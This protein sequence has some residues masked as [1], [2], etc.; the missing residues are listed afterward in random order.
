MNNSGSGDASGTT[1]NGSAPRTISYNTIGA[2]S[3]TGANASGTWSITAT[4]NVLSRGW[5]NWNDSTVINNVVGI[6]AWKNYGNNHVIFD[7]SQGTSPS[8]ASVNQTNS[9]VAWTSSY[10]TL[11]GWNGSTTYGVRVDSARLAD[12]ASTVG[13]FSAD[14]FYRNLGFGSGFPSWNLNTVDENRSGFT[15]SNNAP[16]TGPFIH[17]GASGY[18]LQFN[19][20]YGGDGY[21]LAFRSKNGDTGNWNSWRYPAVYGVNANGGG[22]LYS[23]IYYDQNDTAYYVDPNSTSNIYR[24]TMNE[25]I[26]LGVFPNSTTNTGQAWIGRAADRLSGTMTVQLGGNSPSSRSFEVVDYAW[27]VVLFSAGSDG[28]SIASSSFRAPIFYDSNDT[29]YYADFNTTGTSI[30]IA[31]SLNAATFNK[32]AILVNSSGTSSAGA[33]FGM[34]QVTSEGW[35]GIFVDFEPN[36][37][38]GLYHDNPNNFFLFTA[39]TT[40]GQIGSGFTVPS[41]SSGNRTAYTKFRIDQTTGDVT[42]GRI[43]TA[44]QDMRTPIFYD[45]NN[46]AFYLDPNSTGISSNNAGGAVFRNI[47]ISSASLTDTIQ[48]VNSGGSIWLN[49]GHNGPV[50]LGYGGGLTTAYTGLAVN[51]TS[52]ATGDMRAPIFYDSNDTGYYINPNSDARLYALVV[53]YNTSSAPGV[54]RVSAGHGDSS[55]RLIAQGLGPG[56]TP[57]MQWWVSEPNVTWEWGGFGYNV[58]NDGGSPGGFGRVNTSWGQAYMRMSTGGDWYFYNTNTSGTRTQSLLLTSSGAALFGNT[59]QN[60][61]VWI[62]NG[63]NFNAY[64]ENIRLFNAPNGVSV[65]A[66]SAT[67]LSGM[68]TTSI[69]GYSDRMEFRYGNGVQFRIFDGYTDSTGSSRAPLFYDSNDTFYFVDP[70]STSRLS[71]V[72]AYG[73]YGSYRNDTQSILR[74]YNTSAG[75]PLQFYLDHSFGNVNIGNAR[76]IVYAGGS[77]WEFANSARA[78][79]FY[80]VNNTGYYLNPASSSELDQVNANALN[81]RGAVSATGSGWIIYSIALGFGGYFRCN[82]HMVLDTVNSGYNIYVLDSNS[83]GVVKNSGSSSWSTFSDGTLKTVHSVM[84]NNLSKLESISPIYYSFNNFAD[85]KNRIGL[86]AQEVQEHFPELVEIEPRTQKLVL[87]YTGLIPVLLGAI[88]ELK[89]EVDILKLN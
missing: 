50:G 51:G 59:I 84:E 25:R 49:Y 5:T 83:V 65:I 42:T 14:T 7:A 80:D 69:L 29:G 6:L 34:Q 68:P 67:G 88:K 17:I 12:N 87:D 41:R 71:T 75:S 76:G 61:S 47:Q 85:D 26:T 32:P 74:S 44:Q 56:T 1:Y 10:P 43:A 73:E 8:G 72:T 18:G 13:G 48:N 33:A 82:G 9:A 3:T 62:N 31:G 19:A 27:S 36:T 55:I 39:E 35:T 22:A 58:T 70:N 30:N 78:P 11:M 64:D 24:L 54:F 81:S 4:G 52:S 77:Y 21:G 60:G 46:T 89:K 16:Y 37:G 45:S 38:W 28:N 66:F 53:G 63:G 79:I 40:T 23:T 2:P 15:Y 20:P 57:T 86:I